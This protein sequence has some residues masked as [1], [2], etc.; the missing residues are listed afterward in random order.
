MRILA[1]ILVIPIS[2]LAIGGCGS[3]HQVTTGYFNM[4]T[5]ELAVEKEH[6]KSAVRTLCRR[7]GDQ[8]AECSYPFVEHENHGNVLCC[9]RFATV[10]VTISSDGRSYTP[11]Y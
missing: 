7:T 1:R 11:N 9:I 2:V 8:T 10:K 4:P 6:E 5:L 3:S